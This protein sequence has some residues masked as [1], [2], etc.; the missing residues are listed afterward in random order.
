MNVTTSGSGSRTAPRHPGLKEFILSTKC[1][2]LLTS[3]IC[4]TGV[5]WQMIQIISAYLEYRVVT[6]VYMEKRDEVRPP[7]LSL[8]F[9]YAELLSWH[10]LTAPDGQEMT[11]ETFDLPRLMQRRIRFGSHCLGCTAGAGSSCGGALS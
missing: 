10:G 6:E 8:C 1:S 9:P 11:L 3:L 7:A 5:S 2:L 4:V